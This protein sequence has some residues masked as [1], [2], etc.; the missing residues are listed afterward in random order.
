MNLYADDFDEYSDSQTMVSPN[1]TTGD[2]VGNLPALW[3]IVLIAILVVVRFI[4]PY[5]EK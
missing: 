1:H 4:Q 2:G 3:V 5:A